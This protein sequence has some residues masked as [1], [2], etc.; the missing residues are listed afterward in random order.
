MKRD[1]LWGPIDL[2]AKPV[3]ATEHFVVMGATGSGKSLLIKRLLRGALNSPPGLVNR[4]LIY[5]PKQEMVSELQS[6]GVRA[7]RVRILHPFDDRACCWDMA[8]DIKTPIEAR[9]L[10]TTLI[11]EKQG[12]KGGDSFFTDACRDL[13]SGVILTLAR[14][15]PN[16]Q[17]WTF[18][19]VILAM[20]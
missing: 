5:D 10:A 12:S 19:D 18:R 6:L 14:C 3:A 13:L 4:A 15:A 17:A 11:P 16:P 9:Q 7:G 8:V 20:L 1:L 2:S